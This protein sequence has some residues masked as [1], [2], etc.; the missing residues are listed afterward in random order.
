VKCEEW[1]VESG[2]WRESGEGRRLGIEHRD[3][4]GWEK[5]A[6]SEVQQKVARGEG[7]GLNIGG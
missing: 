3:L 6:G 4:S 2:E 7:Y 1:R 5:G